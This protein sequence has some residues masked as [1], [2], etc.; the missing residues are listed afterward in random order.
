MW[1]MYLREQ[2]NGKICQYDRLVFILIV[3]QNVYFEFG[4][5][6]HHYYRLRGNLRYLLHLKT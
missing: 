3:K 4:Q 1:Y 6:L 2:T 5:V